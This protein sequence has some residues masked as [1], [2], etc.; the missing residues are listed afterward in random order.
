MNGVDILGTILPGDVL[1][2]RHD[3]SSL[4]FNVENLGTNV[5]ASVDVSATQ[6]F[7]MGKHFDG[8][9]PFNGTVKKIMFAQRTYSDEA[10]QQLI[11]AIKR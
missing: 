11:D 3:S 10:M 9:S 4:Q 5:N 7:V 6:R 8:T 2:V 1:V